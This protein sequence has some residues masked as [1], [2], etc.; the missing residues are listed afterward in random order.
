MAK[1]SGGSKSGRRS[2]RRGATIKLSQIRGGHRRVKHGE[3]KELGYNPNRDGVNKVAY[4]WCEWCKRPITPKKI[5]QCTIMGILLDVC[6]RDARRSRAGV[7]GSQGIKARH[8]HGT[9][10]D[11]TKVSDIEINIGLRARKIRAA[12]VEAGA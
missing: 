8:D 10:A 3:R 5:E 2:K 4:S 9:R 11:I 7:F 6:P 1:G 12:K